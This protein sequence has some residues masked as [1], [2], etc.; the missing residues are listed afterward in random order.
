MENACQA[1]FDQN[2]EARA[3]LLA[4][5]KRPL[6]HVVRCDSKTIPG[7]IV[8]QNCMRIGKRLR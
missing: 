2:A 5:D 4:T 1:K 7:V 3:V 8:A 6:M